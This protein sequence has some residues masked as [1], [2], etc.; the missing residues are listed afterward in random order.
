MYF[1]PKPRDFRYNIET[2][3]QQPF[4]KKLD[5]SQKIVHFYHLCEKFDQICITGIPLEMAAK[6]S[7]QV[8]SFG[9]VKFAAITI[10]K[11]LAT[12]FKAYWADNAA[13]VDTLMVR[14]NRDG[15]KTSS[16]YDADNDCFIVSATMRDEDDVNY[17]ICVTSRSDSLFEAYGLCIF[18]IYQL[19]PEQRIPTEAKKNNWG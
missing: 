1:K 11:E 15:W 3:R 6:K 13:D 4:F 5:A 18:K 10:D 19:Y 7:K 12:R 2:W 8:Q 17:D 16:S 9:T 14:A